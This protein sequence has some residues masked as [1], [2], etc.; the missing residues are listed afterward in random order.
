M[1]GGPLSNFGHFRHGSCDW[2][3]QTLKTASW[4]T[5]RKTK[6]GNRTG[7]ASYETQ[8][9]YMPQSSAAAI[10]SAYFYCLGSLSASFGRM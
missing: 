1:T 8:K 9:A 4:T 7:Q 3:T 5:H 2:V 6:L 10:S